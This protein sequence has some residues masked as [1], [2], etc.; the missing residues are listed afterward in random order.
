MRLPA[1]SLI[2]VSGNQNVQI[3]LLES[4]SWKD[5]FV[6]WAA[7]PSRVWVEWPYMSSEAACMQV[8]FKAGDGYSDVYGVAWPLREDTKQVSPQGIL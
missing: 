8:F 3:I 7:R 6:V 2:M 5:Q 1:A 4:V